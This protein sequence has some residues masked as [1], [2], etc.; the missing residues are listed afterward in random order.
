MESSIIYA[1]FVIVIFIIVFLVIREFWAW[2]WKIN[3]I[4]ELLLIQNK[5]LRKIAENV[6]DDE[7]EEK[8]HKEYKYTKEDYTVINEEQPNGKKPRKTL[9]E[10]I[11][12]EKRK[13]LSK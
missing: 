13:L 10:M 5:L 6:A 7:V 9:K 12:E 2:Y 11:E 3:D 4:L 8:E 1:L